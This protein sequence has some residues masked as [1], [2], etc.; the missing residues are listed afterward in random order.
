MVSAVITADRL[1]EL[2]ETLVNIPS[3]TG[4]EDA[5][6]DWIM[7]RLRGRH[8]GGLMRSGRSVVW[9]PVP[10]RSPRPL[11]VLAGHVDTVPAQGNERARREN[12]KLFGLGAT[13]M[14]GGDAVM[15]ALL[16]ALE[17][18]AARFDVA[19]VL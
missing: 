16:D 19:F 4:R 7:G 11:L 18:E 15:L 5:I 12:G 13:D 10:A 1:A 6:A 14:K 2:L 8:G 17:P 9:R 3:V